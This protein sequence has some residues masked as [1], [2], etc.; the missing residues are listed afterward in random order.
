MCV[1]H[2]LT[3]NKQKNIFFLSTKNGLSMYSCVYNCSYMSILSIYGRI[4]T[5]TTTKRLFLLDQKSYKKVRQYI[6][7]HKHITYSHIWVE[8]LNL[9]DYRLKTEIIIV[10]MWMS[11]S[12]K[13]QIKQQKAETFCLF[14]SIWKD[15]MK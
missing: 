1:L 7:Q 9:F 2:V 3:R 13:T 15:K 12:G 8:F 11:G 10:R 4:F 14:Y 6:N 5:E